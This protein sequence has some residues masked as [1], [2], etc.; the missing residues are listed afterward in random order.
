MS[1]VALA[2][3]VIGS[4][5][6]CGPSARAQQAGR[7][8]ELR[9]REIERL[10][11]ENERLKKEN[12]LLKKENA[13][14]HKDP[15][16]KVNSGTG[17]TPAEKP[18]VTVDGVEYVVDKVSRNGAKVTLHFVAVNSKADRNQT[19][20]LVEAVDSD[21]N[22]YGAILNVSPNS[23]VTLTVAL[24]EGVKTHFDI[25]IPNVPAR[26]TEFSRVDISPALS[27]MYG[28]PHPGTIVLKNVRIGK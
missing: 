5:L 20:Y 14:L 7:E 22:S 17:G 11:R 6:V 2:A 15:G 9:K 8:I 21:G 4:L 25:T 18:A 19:F 23:L 13:E 24:R 3:A 12:D 28:P 27:P 26:T 10:E 16:R 1:R